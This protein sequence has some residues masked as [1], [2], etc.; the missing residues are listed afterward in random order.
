MNL[1]NYTL[2]KISNTLMTYSYFNLSNS[3]I[4]SVSSNND[5]QAILLE[6]N[7]KLLH[8]NITNLM[9]SN[10]NIGNYFLSNF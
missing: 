2:F 4:N 8:S 5:A 7:C 9:F 10:S 1:T 6:T 3:I